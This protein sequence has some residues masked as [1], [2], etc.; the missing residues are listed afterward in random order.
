MN[1]RSLLL[2]APLALFP[3][4]GRAQNTV[5]LNASTSLLY[6]KPSGSI[7]VWEAIRPNDAMLSFWTS[8][9]VTS[10]E[11]RV[12]EFS[13][14]EGR[15]LGSFTLPEGSISGRSYVTH[16]SAGSRAPTYY[17]AD[18]SGW[19][20]N[21][22][23]DPTPSV[24]ANQLLDLRA[25][26]LAALGLPSGGAAD[27]YTQFSLR[28][29][30]SMP[31]GGPWSSMTQATVAASVSLSSEY[32]YFQATLGNPAPDYGF[33]P[34]IEIY[35]LGSNADDPDATPEERMMAAD[36]I[37]YD[38]L[39]IESQKSLLYSFRDGKGGLIRDI[40]FGVRLPSIV[41][42]SYPTNYPPLEFAEQVYAI[43]GVPE[44]TPCL[45]L[46]LGALVLLRRHKAQRG[47]R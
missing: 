17:G 28:K 5:Y 45:G 29:G 31:V 4:L 20:S 3:G 19:L 14:G 39:D 2:V 11:H 21:E 35:L 6:A 38:T 30:S 46:G 26:D 10:Q 12:S 41:A 8:D 40:T 18:F 9:G 43:K 33:G 32:E 44:P 24:S 47:A 7:E 36:A 1:L 25:D 27:V 23:E 22:V 15:S 37:R 13:S 16:P 42:P 34:G